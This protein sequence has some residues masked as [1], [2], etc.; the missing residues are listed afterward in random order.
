LNL[1]FLIKISKPSLKL[2]EKISGHLFV[3][4]LLYMQTL[5]IGKMPNWSAVNAHVTGTVGSRRTVVIFYF[6][7]SIYDFQFL[8]PPEAGQLYRIGGKQGLFLEN[9]TPKPILIE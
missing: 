3:I 4:I 2:P 8:N 7:F 9:I 6:L 1:S 5:S